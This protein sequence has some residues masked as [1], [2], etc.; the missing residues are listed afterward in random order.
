MTHETFFAKF[1]LFAEAPDAVAKMRELVL[2]LAVRGKLV[3]QMSTELPAVDC[4]RNANKSVVEFTSI[5]S[6]EL[7]RGW[8]ALPLGCLIASNTGGGTPSKANPN[9]W[10]G[11]IPWASVKDIK[12]EKYLVSTADSIT[13]QG[14][15]NSSS[16]LIPPFRLLIV[17]RM[18]LGK[19]AIN[20][21][22]VAINQDL[23][24]I[25]PTTALDLDFGYL[26]F[27]SLKM[28]GTGV[29]VKGITVEK[30]HE[31]PV[32]LPPIAEQKRIVVKV[33]ELMALCDRLEVQQQDRKNRYT[34]IVRAA[35]ARFSNSPSPANLDLLFHG[36]YEIPPA[37]LRKLI[38]TLAV[39]GKLVPQNPNEVPADIT[40]DGLKVIEGEGNLDSGTPPQWRYCSY[41]SLTSLVTSGSRGW[42]RYYAASG[43]IFIRTQNIKTDNLVLYDAAHVKLPKSAEGM[44]TEVLKD[45]IL[46]TITGANVT[47]AARVTEQIPQAYVNQ[48][49][50]L[51]RP[52]WAV[53]SPW[54]HLCFISH[55]SA[56][57]TLERLAYGDKPGLN[58]DHIRKLLIPIPPLAEQRRIVSKANELLAL[59]SALETQTRCERACSSALLEA[60]VANFAGV[61]RK[62][63]SHPNATDSMKPSALRTWKQRE[64]IEPLK[65]TTRSFVLRRFKMDSPYRSLGPFDCS[66]HL[67]KESPYEASPICLVG[68]NGSGK[69]NL[70]EAVAEVFCFLELINLPW[71]KIE[72]PSS[73]YRENRHRFHLEYTIQ[74]NK[75]ELLIRVRKSKKKGAEFFIVKS[76]G[77]EDPVPSGREQL[78][79]LPRRIVGYSSGLNETVSHPFLRTK[80]IYSEEVRDAAPPE[81]V[82]TPE[83]DRVF[84]TRTLYMD[85]ESNR[86]ILICNFIFGKK[87]ELDV[88]NKYTRV[89]G[90]SS[91]G[92]HFN[93][94]RAGTSGV[95]STVRLTGELQSYLRKFAY[96]AGSPLNETQLFYDFNFKLTHEIKKR[97]RREFKTAENLFMAM[98]KWSLLN[99][100]VLSD[101]Q[102][103]VYLR[104][105]ITNGALER[106]PSV[107]PSDRVF[108]IVDLKVNLSVPRIE[109]DYSG[110]SDGEHQFI[111]VFG[112]AMLFSDPGTLFL[113]DEPES[114]FNP[115][116]RTKFNLILNALRNS[117]RQEYIIS[118][119][120]PFIVSGSRKSNVYKFE[121]DA[122]KIK[123]DPVD[124]ETYGASFDVLLKKLFSVDSL[125][126]QS[127]KQELQE[128][129]IRGKV[130]EMKAAVGEFAE[131]KEKRKLYEAIIT[132]EEK[133]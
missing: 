52:R 71:K 22:S 54:L 115:E 132:K 108:D 33:D 103:K 24:A 35:V 105:D 63:E 46:I 120:S 91:F 17:T 50:A 5:E 38:L 98:H 9:Y 21:V 109:I 57:G 87:S 40:F 86:A 78:L 133:Q 31:M 131:S 11:S 128:I 99:A 47:K 13:E 18:G 6:K 116:W 8:V 114:H 2:Q 4:I 67:D 7:P 126:D 81:G 70:I 15:S 49:I 42:R 73:R 129:I 112:T 16:N 3:E 62:T 130:Q 95:H 83:E 58:L 79:L 100:L 66:F 65:L 111:Q 88:I 74:D 25:E 43:A 10:N 96:C 45:D 75:G 36:S 23:R 61:D 60:A 68:L 107:P 48:H 32:M 77:S 118:T 84:D 123:F 64:P 39:Q 19:L 27:K 92:L 34:A 41:E 44:R 85:Y 26:L 113:L 53:M 119:H 124:F 121:R 117:S 20:K 106:P 14:L 37:D 110:L 93:R 101:E 59:V 29:T 80:T 127:A 30:L 90:V 69:S 56:R 28:V 104:S 1:D 76:D 51:T 122:A 89:R 72:S 125:I 82:L 94:K 97:F 102:R 12:S 55:G